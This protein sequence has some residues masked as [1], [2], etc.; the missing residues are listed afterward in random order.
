M[1]ASMICS[2]RAVPSVPTTSA[3]VSPRV[4]RAEPC[5]ARQDPG[6]NADRTH[7]TRVAA[8]D[9]RIA[10]ENLLAHDLRFQ[11]E[12]HVADRARRIRRR[13]GRQHVRG[14]A[15]VDFLQRLLARLLLAH[16]VRGA[17]L[18]LDG[19]GDLGE[20][21]LILGRR[22][23]FPHG[24]ARFFDQRMDE[25]DDGLLLLV[26]EHHGA[27]HH[28]LGQLVR[29]GL[30]HQHRGFGSGDHEVELRR[31][32]LGLGRIQ[33]VLPVEVSDARGADRARERNAGDRDG[34]RR[35]DQRGNVRID[36]RIDRHHRRDDLHFVVE[37][38]REERA[39]RAVDQA[40]GQ[41]LL[42][43]RASF[44]LE[45]AARDLARGVGLLLVV[46][47]QGKEVLA[48]LGGLRGHA[49]HEDDGV[50]EAR[51]DR[52]PGLAGDLA[53]FE[54]QRVVTVLDGFLDG[55]RHGSHSMNANGRAV[56]TSAAIGLEDFE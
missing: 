31:R 47:G 13:I 3:C 32:E 9:A 27:Q 43:R 30:D 18:A 26:A 7:G 21:R 51:Q 46:D 52:A 24:L 50:A 45:E 15:L 56:A 39:Q 5:G 42:L 44:T 38:V 33:N 4:N 10:R 17:E 35:A 53:R 28:F 2:S 55:C 12:D 14:R 20:E 37:A 23:P 22:L 41:R 54:G 11:V 1:S 40:T 49:R 48:G 36:L 16:L 34:G 8:V 6:A 29:F 19:L 25:V